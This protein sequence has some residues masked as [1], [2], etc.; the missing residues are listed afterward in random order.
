MTESS[1]GSPGKK[2]LAVFAIVDRAG[3]PSSWIRIGNASTNRDGSVTLFLD[4]LPIGTNRLQVRE[5]RFGDGPRNGSA[6]PVEGAAEAR[7]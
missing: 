2:N 6:P 1:A 4:A 5:P 7:P 3:G